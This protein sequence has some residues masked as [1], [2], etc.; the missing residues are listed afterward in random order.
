MPWER[1]L[2]F[3]IRYSHLQLLKVLLA[4]KADVELPD[5]DDKSPL[6]LAIHNENRD[7]TTVLL[8]HGADYTITCSV[9]KNHSLLEEAVQIFS[10]TI[11]DNLVAS[12]PHL[13]L[14]TSGVGYLSFGKPRYVADGRRFKNLSNKTPGKN[15]WGRI[16]D[17]EETLYHALI[18]S[19]PEMVESLLHNSA[20][21]DKK[22]SF[23]HLKKQQGQN[24]QLPIHVVAGYS[25]LD[26]AEV[27]LRNGASALS[28]AGNGW[29]PVR[30]ALRYATSRQFNTSLIG[31]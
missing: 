12:R 21:V 25:K 24:W 23:D 28:K 8:A 20:N 26:M 19:T 22:S 7:A 9:D 2:H 30:L 13:G 15:E 14:S 10:P 18:S 11:L 16:L 4:A 29:L 27:L 31:R 17:E 1:A 5:S 3:A 6:E